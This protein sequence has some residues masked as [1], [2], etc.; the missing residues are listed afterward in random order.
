MLWILKRDGSYEHPKHMLNVFKLMAKE[1][2][3]FLHSKCPFT[4]PMMFV[5]LSE[6]LQDKKQEE[7]DAKFFTEMPCKHYMEVTQLLLK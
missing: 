5:F 1:I 4:E 3:K 2:I 6:K 7:I